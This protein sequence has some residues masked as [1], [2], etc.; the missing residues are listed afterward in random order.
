MLL[1][2]VHGTWPPEIAPT[3]ADEIAMHEVIGDYDAWM[4]E[5]R[6]LSA[7]TREHG[8]AEARSLLRWLR[9]HDK[10]V[11]TLGV[12]DLDA[13]IA[14][15]GISMR[16]SSKVAMVSTLRGVLRYLHGSGRMPI[17]LAD[18]IEGP[19]IYA[20]EG[21]PSTIRR[22]DIERALKAARRDRSPLG[23]RDYAILMLLATYGLRGG[24]IAGLRLSDIDWRH[25]RLRIR[26]VE[27]RGLLGTAVAAWPGRRA[28]RL[29]A[30]RT[31]RDDVPRS[32]PESVGAVPAAVQPRGAP[33]HSDP[34]TQGGRRVPVGQARG[35]C[36]EAQP[37]RVPAEWRRVDQGDRGCPWASQRAVHGRVPQV[38]DRRL[39]GGRAG[40]PGGGV[41]M[42]AHDIVYQFLDTQSIGRKS[43][44]CYV[45]VLRDFDAFVLERAPVDWTALDED[46]ACLAPA[47][48]PAITA[49]QCG[50]PNVRDRPLPRLA[51]SDRGRHPPARGTARAVRSAPESDRSGLLED[52]Y[53]SALERLRPL[54]D[55]GSV[56]GSAMREHVMRMQSLGYRYEVRMRDL[57]RFDRFLQRHPD[58]AAASLPQTAGG[59]ASRKP[60]CATSTA[61]AAVRTG[62]VKG[63]APQWTRP[64][65][66]LSI[67]AGLQSPGGPA[68]AAAA[69]LYRS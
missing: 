62:T 1:R 63:V 36:P 21:I 28:A 51:D 47:R 27:D 3:T 41:A 38:G 11:A 49:D 53:E 2:L 4:V 50:A 43:R 12:A 54:P 18:A 42:R 48:N 45:S 25:E 10:S 33:F 16:R 40:P 32:V 37:R 57:R 8:R 22:E 60:R 61:G 14:S 24:E 55:W 15:R 20:L 6:G 52:D 19:P 69:S 26:H 59:L 13:Y 7:S 66:I 34:P 67:E 17:D 39:E 30:T 65:P 56:L 64:R 58:L 44:Y 35:A 29:P 23:R 68:R 46:A 9:D 5:L 31:A